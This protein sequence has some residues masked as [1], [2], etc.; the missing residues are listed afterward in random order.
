MCEAHDALVARIESGDRAALPLLMDSYRR[1]LTEHLN[2]RLPP[3][4]RGDVAEDLVQNA[5]T[6]LVES[7]PA[8]EWRGTD[9]F[10]GWLRTAVDARFNDWCRHVHRLR[11]TYRRIDAGADAVTHEPA[12]SDTPLRAPRTPSATRSCTAS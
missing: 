4:L 8:F 6:S 11:R 3:H 1:E 2:R 7:L 9:A 10:L 5:F 12:D